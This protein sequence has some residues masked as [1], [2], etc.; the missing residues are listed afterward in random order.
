MVRLFTHMDW[1][2]RKYEI[3]SIIR[4]M[5]DYEEISRKAFLNTCK[6]LDKNPKADEDVIYS[7]YLAER[8]NLQKMRN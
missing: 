1:V 8:E 5:S 3:C 2:N 6:Q 4:F 7:W